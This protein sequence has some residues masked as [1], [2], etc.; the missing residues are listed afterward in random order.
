MIFDK[1]FPFS[2]NFSILEFDPHYSLKGCGQL[3]PCRKN[4][5]I[6]DKK[7][8]D[9]YITRKK[10]FKKQVVS[11]VLKL[12]ISIDS[13]VAEM[14]TIH[15]GNAVRDINK[16]LKK[17]YFCERINYKTYVPD[18]F[19]IHSSKEERQGRKMDDQ[20]L[21][22]IEEMG[23]A[24]KQNFSPTVKNCLSHWTTN[25]GV[26]IKKKGHS[27]GEILLNNK[28][29]GY[30]TLERYGELLLYSRFIGHGDHLKNGI[31]YLL[32]NEIIKW[33][34]DKEQIMSNGIKY[35]MYA[36]WRDGSDGLKRWKKRTLFKPYYLKT[37]Y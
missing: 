12:P 17:E 18:I 24:P 34:I 6:F 5:E 16:A 15:K 10:P 7:L 23:G 21:I 11:A 31:M 22:S 3:G 27:Q 4:N 26:L 25:Y 19:D 35:I 33:I 29:V 9:R 30:I 14:R 8:L 20:Y 2:P 28:L 13:Y 32:N 37:I 1:I 36:G